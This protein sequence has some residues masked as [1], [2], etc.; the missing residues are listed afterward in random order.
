[1]TTRTEH[2]AVGLPVPR[3]ILALMGKLQVHPVGRPLLIEGM[4]LVRVIEL[5]GIG[6]A[7]Q[8]ARIP[9]LLQAFPPPRVPNRARRVELRLTV[10]AAASLM[11]R[12]PVERHALNAIPHPQRHIER[13]E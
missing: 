6:Q 11:S 3:L 12:T 9:D 10:I 5:A 13:A 4:G 1:M 2:H 7:A 8:F